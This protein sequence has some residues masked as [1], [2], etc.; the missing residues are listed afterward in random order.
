M[1]VTNH[2]IMSRHCVENLIRRK[3]TNNSYRDRKNIL[4][5]NGLS[6][7]LA[8]GFFS[9]LTTFECKIVSSSSY[10]CYSR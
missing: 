10:F 9:F 2:A 3:H 7:R 4:A 1:F 6:C 5:P 8:T